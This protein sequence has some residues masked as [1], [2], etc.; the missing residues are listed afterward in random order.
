[1]HNHRSATKRN[2]PPKK[3]A[4]HLGK[5]T[6]RADKETKV[7]ANMSANKNASNQISQNPQNIYY[8]QIQVMNNLEISYD[9]NVKYGPIIDVNT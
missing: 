8:Y 5:T 9:E 4:N 1:M 7:K 3:E 2:T 6:H